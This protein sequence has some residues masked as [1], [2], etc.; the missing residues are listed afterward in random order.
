MSSVKSSNRSRT[1]ETVILT[2]TS[3]PSEERSIYP[4]TFVHISAL[5]GHVGRR[6]DYRSIQRCSECEGF[7]ILNM[8]RGIFLGNV[9][10]Q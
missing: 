9:I 1:S 8:I 6:S 4:T 2:N 3:K 10:S 7:N 5:V